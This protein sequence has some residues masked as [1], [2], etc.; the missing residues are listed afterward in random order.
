MQINR[1]AFS[2]GGATLEEHRARGAN[3]EVDVPWKYLNF[4]MEDDEKLAR[5]GQEYG[6]G[7]ML[8]GGGS[9]LLKLLV[10]SI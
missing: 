7:R 1:Y 3:L 8:T 6:A 4:F 2:G 5:I 10:L 9:A